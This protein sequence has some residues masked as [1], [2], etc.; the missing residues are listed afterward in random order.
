MGD[1]PRHAEEEEELDA[2][3]GRSKRLAPIQRR[4]H[5]FGFVYIV[6]P[7]A[8]A[9]SP[10]S[11]SIYRPFLSSSWPSPSVCPWLSPCTGLSYTFVVSLRISLSEFECIAR[12]TLLKDD[13]IRRRPSKDD[14]L[15]NCRPKTRM[16]SNPLSNLCSMSPL[17]S[18]F[19]DS[20]GSPVGTRRANAWR[21]GVLGRKDLALFATGASVEFYR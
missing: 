8:N 17:A 5:I 21:S 6:A 7:Y 2:E 16:W 1:N 11:T 12:R 10:P 19:A 4:Y 14:E 20:A 18:A 13:T 15:V 9:R 3:S